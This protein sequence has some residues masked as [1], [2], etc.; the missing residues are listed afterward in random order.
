VCVS[1]EPSK[2]AS[3]SQMMTEGL[4]GKLRARWRSGAGA[5][6]LRGLRWLSG[7]LGLGQIATG[8]DRGSGGPAGDQW[9]SS[10]SKAA[11]GSRGR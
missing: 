7:V 11:R 3:E 10:S 6:E 8:P 4:Q 2:M 1:E 5:G 9:R